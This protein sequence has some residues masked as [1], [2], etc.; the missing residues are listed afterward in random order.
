MREG[1]FRG[2]RL[3]LSFY[4]FFFCDDDP[5]LMRGGLSTCLPVCSELLVL[6][7]WY[8]IKGTSV[9]KTD[10]F[11]PG[12]T[13]ASTNSCSSIA[14]SSTYLC[15]THIR[16]KKHGRVSPPQVSQQQVK[17]RRRAELA[18]GL[19]SRPGRKN[20]AL[21]MHQ[22]NPQYIRHI[23]RLSRNPGFVRQ[24]P[25]FIRQILSLSDKS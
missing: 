12:L 5:H 17:P 6:M 24:N 25:E 13:A 9:E 18:T 16:E 20:D 4:P 15:C 10:I 7:A 11:R 22:A 19:L 14:Q 23:L 1:E 3:S 2:K 21:L 8:L